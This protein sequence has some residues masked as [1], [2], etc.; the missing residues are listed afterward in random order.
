[1]LAKKRYSPLWLAVILSVVLLLW[2]VSG[3]NFRAKDET[4]AEQKKLP[5]ALN[6]VEVR[7][8]TAVQ[9][10]A[11]QVAQGQLKAWRNVSIKAQLAGQVEAILKQQGDSVNKGEKLIQLSDEGR[12]SQL[13]QAQA[14]LTLRQQELD[15][16]RKLGK[17]QFLSATELTRLESELARAQAELASA[18]L[19][20]E[21]SE[22]VAPFSGI[23]DKRTVEV[24]DLV[25]YGTQLMQLVQIDKLKVSAQIP[26]QHI[27]HVKEGQTATIRLLDGRQLNAV[28]SFISYAADEATRSFYVELTAD[29]PERWRIA[30]A[31]ATAEITLTPVP[32]HRLSPALLRLD[33]DGKLGVAV[34]DA[35]NNVVIYP[36]QLLS[37]DND[38]AWVS[39]LPDNVQLITQGAGFVTAGEQV[40]IT[41]TT[42]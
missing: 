6:Q 18:E 25:Q 29:N 39:G 40:E 31:S 36:V 10:P 23:V 34:A 32:A 27:Q 15:S 28:V 22:P 30:G 12:R 20:I 5:A 41:G 16:A 13:K 4:P 3:D 37:A 14:N 9:Y 26:Q 2:L 21:H 24:G 42:K 7:Q 8:S 35:Q 38:G 19:A 33:N 1:M 11:T 17:S